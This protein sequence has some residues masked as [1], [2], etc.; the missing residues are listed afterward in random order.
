MFYNASWKMFL[1]QNKTDIEFLVKQQKRCFDTAQLELLRH[2]KTLPNAY[3]ELVIF[4]NQ[5]YITGKRGSDSGIYEL[6][7]LYQQE[8]SLDNLATIARENHV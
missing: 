2:I 3:S 5:Q 7:A 8:G 4:G 1:M 6:N